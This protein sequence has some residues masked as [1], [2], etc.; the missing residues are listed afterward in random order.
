MFSGVTKLPK[1]IS[2]PISS[3]TK[4]RSAANV[5]ISEARRSRKA[6]T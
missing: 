6:R 4:M 2:A 5:G 1:W 3:R